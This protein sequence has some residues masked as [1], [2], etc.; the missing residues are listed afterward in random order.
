MTPDKCSIVVLVAVNV[1]M[2]VGWVLDASTW[3]GWL[4]PILLAVLYCAGLGVWQTKQSISDAIARRKAAIEAARKP[5][6]ASDPDEMGMVKGG[7][8]E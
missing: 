3:W 5:L 2:F 4:F 7:L 1:W 6:P 8:I